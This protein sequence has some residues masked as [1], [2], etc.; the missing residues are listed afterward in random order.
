[1]IIVLNEWILME[2]L[3]HLMDRFKSWSALEN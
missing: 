1:M 2:S 3:H